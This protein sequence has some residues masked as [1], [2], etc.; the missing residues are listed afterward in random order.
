VTIPQVR[1]MYHGDYSRKKTL[2]DHGFRLPSALDNRPMKFNEFEE[3]LKT[4]LFVSATPGNYELEKCGGEIVELIIRPTGLL[5]PEIEVRPAT[6]QVQNLIGEV[7]KHADRGER[8]LVT[9]LTKRLAEDLSEFLKDEGLRGAYLHSEIDTFQ[10]VEILRD[11]RLGRFDA[12]VGVNLLREGLDLPEVT[13]VA[14]LDADKEGFLRS[15][16]SLIQTIGRTA[17]NVNAKVILYADK[18]TKSMERAIGETRRRREIQAAHNKRHGI[19]PE[20]IRKEIRAGI[21][22]EITDRSYAHEAVSE[23]EVAYVTR[24]HLRE[25]EGEMLQAAEELE[26]ERAAELRDR[27]LKLQGKTSPSSATY[28]QPKR[29]KR[30]TRKSRRRW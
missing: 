16:T 17:R 26:F 30:R 23:D 24:E 25:L 14:I 15:E 7:R 10:R 27:I 18:I 22:Q 6:N 21:E 28:N 11:L 29:H 8:V 9:T 5:D 2:V 12:L 19:K 20:T 13:L 1:A 4:V 3:A